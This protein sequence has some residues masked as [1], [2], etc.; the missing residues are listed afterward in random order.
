MLPFFLAWL[1]CVTFLPM[2]D[3]V[4]L[5]VLREIFC[6]MPRVDI[7]IRPPRFFFAVTS[8]T[9]VADVLLLTMLMLTMTTTT[10]MVVWIIGEADMLQLS[11]SHFID[12]VS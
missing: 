4:T 12:T 6:L 2:T 3:V 7:L 11:R 8:R 1:A 5:F 10:T 9:L